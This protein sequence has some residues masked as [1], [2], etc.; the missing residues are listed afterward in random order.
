MTIVAVTGLAREARIAAGTSVKTV[1]SG[2]SAERLRGLLSAALT[3]DVEAIIS[4]GIAGG[5]SHSLQVGDCVIASE[6]V[7]PTGRFTVHKTWTAN[8]S[9]RLLYASIAPIAGTDAILTEPSAK[10]ALHAATGAA[11]ADMES[12]VAAQLAFERNLPFAALRTISDTAGRALPDAVRQALNPDGGTNLRA[13]LRSV[14]RNPGQI[15]ALIR[16][17]REAETAFRALL[18]C[19]NLLDAR[20][21]AVDF[22]ELALDMR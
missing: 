13:V 19:R 12:H 7:G 6:I 15:P 4:F 1:I 17:G 22:G 9:A 10:A 20:L 8:L 5:L 3:E 16:T 11:A 18:R 21:G 2:G 14:L